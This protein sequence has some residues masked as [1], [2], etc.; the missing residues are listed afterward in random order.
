MY[1][2]VVTIT[3]L[4]EMAH[5]GNLYNTGGYIALLDKAGIKYYTITTA[6]NGKEVHVQFDIV[7][8]APIKFELFKAP[9]ITLAGTALTK[10]NKKSNSADTG[11]TL[12]KYDPTIG[13]DGI[14][15]NPTMVIGNASKGGGDFFSEIDWKILEPNQTFLIKFTGMGI[16][17]SL[18][19]NMRYYEHKD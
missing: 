6:N 11:D 5:D 18:S 16:T 9:T 1:N 10:Y 7:V 4:H 12:F 13:A 8:L 19:W 15:T 2:K 14:L 3:F 17:T